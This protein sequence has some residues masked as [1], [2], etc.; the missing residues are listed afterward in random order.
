MLA[1]V[2]SGESFQERYH[3]RWGGLRDPHVRALAWLIDAPDL[4]DFHAPQWRGQIARLPADAGEQAC[5][6]LHALD[7]APAQL[8][9]SLALQPFSR[10]G[11][12]AERLMAFYLR[13]LG[14]LAAENLQ[15]REAG[16]RT[17]G[18][19]DFL[20]WRGTKLL[21]W[22]FATK[23]YLLQSPA[24]PDVRQKEADYFVGPNLADS[25]GAKMHKIFDRQLAL[26]Q[27]PAA[28][29]LLPQAVDIA[30]AMVKG[31]LFYHR[32]QRRISPTA[33]VA[34]SHC[35]GFWCSLGEVAPAEA[36]LILPRLSWL[37]PARL[38]A[39][40][41]HL[42]LDRAALEGALA[43]A[44]ARDRM[45]VLVALLRSAGGQALEWNRGFIVPEDWAGRAHARLAPVP[46]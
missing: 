27:H 36:Y 17:V 2:D 40:D 19:F 34:T 39:E 16:K 30:E 20:V 12:Y 9:A 35:H 44:F 37:A 31:W 41:A 24:G 8:H 14:I 11:R 23:F 26:G 18:E 5:D 46:G 25:L 22:E 6:W 38:G 32:G 33:G 45:P 29:P 21:H 43:A 28:Q 4:L 1:G 10:L 13:H 15:V 42:A 3:R 7:Q